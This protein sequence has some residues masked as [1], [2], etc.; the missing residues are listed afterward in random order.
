MSK[1][2]LEKVAE[3]EGMEI[4]I[5]KMKAQK[6]KEIE[7]QSNSIKFPVKDEKIKE[8]DL[9]GKEPLKI[10][11]PTTKINSPFADE[12][13]GVWDF[14][15]T[16]QKQLALPSIEIDDFIEMMEYTDKESVALTEVFLAPMR[17]ILT[18]ASYVA[19]V[20]SALPKGISFCRKPDSGNELNIQENF[21][22]KLPNFNI[23]SIVN[24]DTDS[25][26]DRLVSEGF[27]S[28]F[29][30]LRLLP[31]K[32]SPTLVCDPLIWQTV[33]RAILL[34]DPSI[35]D[36]RNDIHKLYLEYDNIKRVV[37]GSKKRAKD[38][39]VEG[40]AEE[41]QKCVEDLNKYAAPPIISREAK[42]NKINTLNHDLFLR[43]NSDPFAALENLIAAAQALE[44][45]ELHELS[46]RHKISILKVLCEACFDTEFIGELLATNIEER[47]NRITATRKRLEEKKK[48]Q[49]EIANCKKEDAIRICWLANKS[50]ADAKANKTKKKATSE[51][52]PTSATKKT[53]SPK[54]GSKYKNEIELPSKKDAHY[55]KQDQVNA[56][57]E[58]LALL[59]S[60]KIDKV[61]DD[62]EVEE[63]SDD[64]DDNETTQT[65]DYSDDGPKQKNRATIRSKA[66][67][68]KAAR[69][70][71]RY[72]NLNI[73]LANEFLRRA[74]E[75]QA[76]KDIKAAIKAALKAGFEGE[77]DDGN[78][79]CTQLLKQLYKLR[80][81]L[82][83]KAVEEAEFFK[84]DKAMAEYICRSE[85]I[86][87][88]RHM[89]EYWAFKGDNRL[90]VRSKV[91]TDK[92]A[93]KDRLTFLAGHLSAANP[94]LKKFYQ[95]RPYE[96]TYQWGM[97]AADSE[98]WELFQALDERGERESALKA[99]I[100]ARFDI[101]PP[102]AE[103][104]KTGSEYIGRSIA[105]S[106][107][108]G[109]KP[110]KTYVGKIVG[111][112]PPQDEDVALWHVLHAD[113]DEEDLE[114]HEVKEYLISDEEVARLSSS[115]LSTASAPTKADKNGSTKPQP[116][117]EERK[118]IPDAIKNFRSNTS[119]SHQKLKDA[120]LGL[121]GLKSEMLR[122]H[123]ML[124]DSLKNTKQWIRSVQDAESLK[125]LRN[126]LQQLE[127]WVHELQ[128]V[129]DVDDNE[130]EQRET[131]A[132]RDQM[133][134]DGWDFEKD[135]YISKRIRRFF[136]GQPKSDGSIIAFLPA[137]KNEG[138]NWWRCVYDDHDEEDLAEDTVVLGIRHFEENAKEDET[139]IVPEETGN[140]D[141][142]DFLNETVEMEVMDDGDDDVF[143][144]DEL[145]D[146]NSNRS[147][148]LWPTIG[149]RKRWRESVDKS[150][151][152]S[153]VAL[154]LTSL[155][156]FSKAF[157]VCKADPSDSQTSSIYG[158]NRSSANKSYSKSASKK[159]KANDD[160]DDI[161]ADTGRVQRSVARKV[162]SYAE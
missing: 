63:V 112:L 22:Q 55:P 128:D 72:R 4:N 73:S 85:P 125:E 42:K 89:N 117:N 7:R 145:I 97:F 27:D 13:V 34:R 36:L 49:R 78:T 95:T 141:D 131:K 86:G 23:K 115:A 82:D 160:N 3:I 15:N 148:C 53:A 146:K 120:Q 26:V 156:E 17:I 158:A 18:D 10:P 16:F 75:T 87:R 14:L 60:L 76:E 70:E 57:I 59:D 105:R 81:D 132:S 68:K 91:A 121:I 39:S 116:I 157:G 21:N 99:T 84:Q 149:V 37:S 20:S 30:G 162:I 98:M 50:A 74:L 5:V 114:E 64:E 71:K 56:M 79:F 150:K 118:D 40:S 153:E 138:E 108:I 147:K 104:I 113:G 93:E 9:K 94:I 80:H 47:A 152:I 43:L 35:R 143:H 140:D 154:A 6:A 1:K 25:A 2:E 126:L 28:S 41:H 107:T 103:Y 96:K 24:K 135:Q 67:E 33:L 58:E 92:N 106:Y 127:D 100:K 111:W 52:V 61:I 142:D 48:E 45:K 44:S 12:I 119:R 123:N 133:K 110:T 88:D 102:S 155:I 161:Y 83:V 65:V 144:P 19:K 129:S 11:D 32:L 124:A 46:F 31:R 137:D 62:L 29:N 69:Q 139:V 77:D 136:P 51:A 134:R 151:T 8:L 109:K 38:D 130:E 54:K 101:K 122:S 66:G 159:R 90:F